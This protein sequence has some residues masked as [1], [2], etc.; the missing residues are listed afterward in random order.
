[1]SATPQLRHDLTVV[2]Q[3][4]R[5][6][7][8]YIVKDPKTRKYFRFKPLEMLVMQEFDGRRTCPEVARVLHEQGLPLTS[9]KVEGFARKPSS[10]Q[11]HSLPGKH[12]ANEMVGGRPR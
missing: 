4:F 2:E 1:M 8:S 5:G 10:G 12:A 11:T 7:Q 6:E 3:T 9:A